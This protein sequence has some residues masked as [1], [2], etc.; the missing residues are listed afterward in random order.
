MSVFTNRAMSR[1]A[2]R[3]LEALSLRRV[4]EAA[5]TERLNGKLPSAVFGQ[6]TKATVGLSNLENLNVPTQAEAEAGTSNAAMCTPKSVAQYMDKRLE[7][8]SSEKGVCAGYIDGTAK[9][10]TSKLCYRLNVALNQADQDA[11]QTAKESFAS[12]FNDWTRI[13]HGSNGT[14]PSNASEVN[15]WEYLPDTDTIR[16]TLNSNTFIG[17]ISAESF[18]DYDFETEVSSTNGDDDRIGLV[19]AY[20]VSGGKQYTLS[21]L[22]QFDGYVNAGAS[23]V[24]LYNAFQPGAYTLTWNDAGLGSPNPYHNSLG[25]LKTGWV[26]AGKIRIKVKRRGDIIEC[27]TTLPNETTYLEDKKITIDLNSDNRL[28]IFKGPQRFGYC[29]QSQLY[30][31]WRSLQRPGAKWPIVR[32]DTLDTFIW[33]NESWVKQPVGTHRQYVFPRR[34]FTNQI[35]KRFFFALTPDVITEITKE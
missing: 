15:A 29:C 8:E 5:D 31:S 19:I 2:T 3:F 14:Y 12:V 4:P 33:Q 30:A 7:L 24:A 26:G 6:V 11:V 1:L 23:F 28:A 10:K 35:T 34:F 25:T 32:V 16:A 27:W 20:V 18:D 9:F 17:F 21:I 13:S 22:R